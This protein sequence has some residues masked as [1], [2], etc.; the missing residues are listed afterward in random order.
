MKITALDESADFATLDIE[1]IFSKIK[2]HELS[3]KGHPNH[4]ASFTSKA[5]VTSS[6]VVGHDANPINA[7]SS[8]LE[9]A[10]P[11]LATTSDE[12][13]ESIA[14]DEIALLARKFCAL[15]KFHKERRRSPGAT[16]SA[17]TPL[18]S[19]PIAP[20]GRSF[21]PLTSMTMPTGMT[22]ATRVIIR[23]RTASELGVCITAARLWDLVLGP[24]LCFH[25]GRSN[26]CRRS[27]VPTRVSSAGFVFVFVSSLRFQLPPLPV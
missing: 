23:R 3:R 6:C 8:A 22:L 25:A 5:L 24:S 9:F 13:Y 19:S 2:S 27:P 7:V 18:T 11:S 14:D 17:V 12:Q 15:H 21:T 4:N 10:L 16:S 26:F 20:R 1:K